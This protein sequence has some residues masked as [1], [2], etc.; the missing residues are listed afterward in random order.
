M[1]MSKVKEAVEGMK[2]GKPKYRYVLVQDFV[3]T[4]RSGF[5]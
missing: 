2:E 3:P 5:H 4:G 1:P